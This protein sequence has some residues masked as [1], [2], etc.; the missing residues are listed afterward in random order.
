MS[1]E[2]TR[3]HVFADHDDG[4]LRLLAF[5][6]G[7]FMSRALEK[8]CSV[9]I[10]RA[11]ECDLSIDHPSVSRRHACVHV[12]PGAGVEIEDLGSANGTRVG[13]RVLRAGE[14]AT[15]TAET[16]A[17]VGAAAV[18][19]RDAER[20][21]SGLPTMPPPPSA[22]ASSNEG[23]EHLVKLVAPSPLSIILLGETGV[24][25]EVTAQTIHRLSTRAGGPFVGL[26]CAALT[27]SLLEAELFGYTRGSFTGATK[28]KPGLLE[29]ANGGSVFLDELGEMPL[30]TQAKLLRV[31]ENRE[32]QRIGG[33]EPRPIDVRFIAA[34]NRDL[35]QL[36]AEGAFRRDLFYRLNGIT[37]RIRPL[38]DRR[39][40]I[41]ALAATFLRNAA[42][43]VG[44]ASVVLSR[45]ALAALAAHDWPGNVRELRAVVERAVFLCEG[46]TIRP[47]HLQLEPAMP[48]ASARPHDAVE[49]EGVGS[50]DLRRS[51]QDHEKERIIQ[52]LDRC[53][54]NQTRAAEML[55]I[56]RRTLVARLTEYGL[57][58]PRKDSTRGR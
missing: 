18:V 56:S 20:A 29:V 17:D 52:A 50:A 54:G 25:K 19:V 37:I 24:G 9:V 6:P 58:R 51:V 35:H 46:T 22:P 36:V 53:D 31:V 39:D 47:D 33:L 44:K 27:E 57:P 40:E 28:D 21:S 41:P 13:R 30:T 45:E 55:G 49:G 11:L 3:S 26:N 23:V 5:W 15:L 12:G 43:A 48:S 38:R 8:R 14:R 32:I 7:G 42:G 4:G 2:R 16:V 34:T 10:G 1:D